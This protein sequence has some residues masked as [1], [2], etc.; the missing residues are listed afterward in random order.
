M[1]FLLV[2]SCNSLNLMPFVSWRAG[3]GTPLPGA[4]PLHLAVQLEKVEAVKLLLQHKVL[5][6]RWLDLTVVR[7]VTVKPSSP[8]VCFQQFP[9][10]DG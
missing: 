2:C 4:A 6:T 7:G 10:M 1:L 9:Q 8:L 3:T 5:W